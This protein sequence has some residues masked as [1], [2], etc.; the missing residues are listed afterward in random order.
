MT[1]QELISPQVCII[2]GHTVT[3]SR[4]VAEY[5]R[6]LHKHVV[7]KIQ[8]LECSE[9]FLTANFSA[10]P[11]NHNGNEYIEYQITRDG[12]MFLAMGFTGKKAATFKEAYINEFNRLEQELHKAQ[13]LPAPKELNE[14]ER[15][16]EYRKKQDLIYEQ[17]QKEEAARIRILNSAMQSMAKEL[18]VKTPVVVIDLA[19]IRGLVQR[20]RQNQTNI[21]RAAAEYEYTDRTINYLKSQFDDDFFDARYDTYEKRH[22]RRPG[23]SIM[24]Y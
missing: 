16:L 9:E 22:G 14:H 5:F 4:Q 6:K 20:I 11:Y 19:V 3:T 8:N 10:V 17:M 24:D 2:D 18:E 21:E 12:F 13:S 1:S 23:E 15:Y 7:E